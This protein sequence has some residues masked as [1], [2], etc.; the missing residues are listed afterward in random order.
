[1]TSTRK[2]FEITRRSMLLGAAS[3]GAGALAAG[4]VMAKAPMKGVARPTGYRFGLGGFEIATAFD[5]YAQLPGPH[6]IFGE[7]AE[8]A[9]VEALMTENNLPPT[10]MEIGFTPIMVNTGDALILFD[11]GNGDERAATQGKLIDAMGA[12]GYSPEDVDIV[13]F[14]HFHPDHIGGMT[15]LDE[16]VFMNARYVAPRAEFEFWKQNADMR[17]DGYKALLESRIFAFAEKMTFLED[18]QDVVTGVTA[19]AASGHTPG[20]TAYHIESEGRRFVIIGD[21]CNHYVASLERPDWHVR[22]DMNKEDAVATRKRLLDMLATDGVPFS[23]YH[24]PFPAVGYVERDGS[25][26]RYAA[27]SYQFVL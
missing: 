17:G 3:A 6:P 13:V 4:G 23:G 8:A 15:S 11:T 1:M 20:H 24:M 25:G 18:G 9:A 12:L 26:Y 16:P 2:N 7:N 21:A 14:T 19:M 10:R 22:F 5:G 27:A